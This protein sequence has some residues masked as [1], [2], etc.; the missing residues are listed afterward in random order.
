MSF[1]IGALP[2]NGNFSRMPVLTGLGSGTVW[3]IISNHNSN[4]QYDKLEMGNL[5]PSHITHGV[6]GN[7]TMSGG[8]KFP[9]GTLSDMDRVT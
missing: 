2:L 5:W 9:T 1:L 8:Q 6:C 3:L 7:S 4:I